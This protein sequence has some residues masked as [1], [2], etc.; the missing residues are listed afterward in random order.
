MITQP[1]PQPQ[2]LSNTPTITH[3]KHTKEHAHTWNRHKSMHTRVLTIVPFH[4]KCKDGVHKKIFPRGSRDTQP[5]SGLSLT[6]VY[7]N[8][9]VIRSSIGHS[10]QK[11]WIR[12][13]TDFC[14]LLSPYH[15]CENSGY[16]YIYGIKFPFCHP[17]EL[18]IQI[19]A[20]LHFWI[21]L[22]NVTIPKI[23]D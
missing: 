5:N 16:I 19:W 15:F 6:A 8:N 12:M 1:Q 20:Q 3:I 21:R 4:Y 9:T 11:K 10:C 22:T 18:Q 17:N 13:L 7:Y 2:P 23:L 14:N